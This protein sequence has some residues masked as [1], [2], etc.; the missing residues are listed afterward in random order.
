MARHDKQIAELAVPMMELCDGREFL[1]MLPI[2][3]CTAGELGIEVMMTIT[4]TRLHLRLTDDPGREFSVDILHVAD[5]AMRAIDAQLRAE[6]LDDQ[7]GQAC[8]RG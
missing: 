2:G 8:L 3:Q 4:G 1:T 7:E 6:K 5:L